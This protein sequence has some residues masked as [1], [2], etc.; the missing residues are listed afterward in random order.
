M[1]LTTLALLL[2][3]I[4]S[5]R[6]SAQNLSLP[7]VLQQQDLQNK[8]SLLKVMH[9]PEFK[10]WQQLTAQQLLA[11]NTLAI[12]ASDKV[13]LHILVNNLEQGFCTRTKSADN[14]IE[15]VPFIY[16][17][18][19]KT[20]CQQ[21]NEETPAIQAVFNEL[22]SPLSDR[23]FISISDFAGYDLGMGE[24]YL[25]SLFNDAKSSL[26]SQQALY[27]LSTLQDF[28]VYQSLLPYSDKLLKQEF[29]RRFMVEDDLL[30]QTEG[31]SVSA[32]LLRSKSWQ[33]PMPTAMQMSIYSD[34]IGHLREAASVINW[35]SKQ[36]WSDAKWACMAA[37]I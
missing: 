26:S 13:K 15:S 33:K 8:Q 31:G 21:K 28:Y 1:R 30:I 2:L 29:N 23:E 24:D 12:T 22:V 20:L 16:Q 32:T 25:F 35:V 5:L 14:S 18:Y 11:Q 37:V 34:D 36:H 4:V 3:W 27:L 6:L 7:D 17:L 10:T 9:K 19:V